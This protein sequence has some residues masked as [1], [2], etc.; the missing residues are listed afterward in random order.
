[1]PASSWRK[2]ARQGKIRA[3]DRI[4]EA[5]SGS[6][7]IALAL[8]WRKLG[9]R[10]TAVLPEGVSGERVLIIRA[11]G[12]E[13]VLTPREK[14][15][16][17]AIG[18]AERLG[19][20]PETFLPR[21]FRNPD[22]AEAHRLGTAREILDQIPSGRVQGVVSG[23]GTGGTLVGLYEGFTEA[24][25][26]VVPGYARPV[27]LRARRTWSVAR[28]APAS[29]VSPRI[30]RTSSAPRSCRAC[31]PSKWPTTKPCKPLVP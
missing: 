30:S 16:V 22:N 24:G 13:V 12:G 23:V 9:L 8:A 19:E 6:T 10:F 4:I 2:P 18:E 31:G 28:S 27:N 14:G 20:Q 26:S 21:Q 5:S 3:G 17:G 15:I 7:S 25:N 11:Y 1:M 29:P